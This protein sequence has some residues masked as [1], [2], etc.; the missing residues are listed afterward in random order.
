M[1][2]SLIQVAPYIDPILTRAG[3]L[4]R[5][6]LIEV[7]GKPGAGKTA[8]AT[9][10]MIGAQKEGL[11][12]GYIASERGYDAE[13][14][15]FLG[16][17][18]DDIDFCYPMFAEEW[19]T[20]VMK[21]CE[22]NYGLIVVDSVVGVFPKAQMED[23]ED[24]QYGPIA[25]VLSRHLPLI[26]PL[27]Y[28]HNTCVLLLNQ[29]RDKFGVFGF[30]RSYDSAGGWAIKHFSSIRLEV[31]RISNIQYSNNSIGFI[32]EVKAWKNRRFPPNRKGYFSVIYDMQLPES[33][34]T[35]KLQKAQE[36][37]RKN[38][39]KNNYRKRG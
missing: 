21:W 31:K 32:A 37:V 5:G 11:K 25:K 38:Y 8:F 2:D 36:T 7:T 23:E 17:N 19:L 9:L 4:P 22:E 15:Q 10:A 26:H 12:V 14:A 6:L 33:I 30:G 1:Q 35:D 39:E 16:L 24:N 3:G 13:Y 29:V 20:Q 34:Y 18:P 27:A 28:E